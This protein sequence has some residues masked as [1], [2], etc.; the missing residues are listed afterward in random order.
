MIQCVPKGVCSWNYVLQGAAEIAKVDFHLV[1]EQ[2][3]IAIGPR[4]F[5][6]KKHGVGSGHWTL[7]EAGEVIV[8]AHKKSPLRRVFKM[9]STMG[10]LKLEAELPMKRAFLLKHHDKELLRIAPM[11]ALTKR[12]TIDLKT[13]EYEL[14]VVSFAFWLVVLTWR[15]AGSSTVG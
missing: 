4:V 14:P 11:H 3:K 10:N 6:V 12:A 2:G 9:H 8:S 1:K 7:E 13:S 5:D 15:R